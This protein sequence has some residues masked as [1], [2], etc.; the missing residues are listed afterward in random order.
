[1]NNHAPP[2]LPL[3]KPFLAAVI[4]GILTLACAAI[5]NVPLTQPEQTATLT[6][7]EAQ[8]PESPADT[9]LPT[10]QNTDN[11]PSAQPVFLPP[12][13]LVDLYEQASR[14][15]V[16]IRILS[17]QGGGLG[18]GFVIDKA[19]YIVTNF[20]VIEG[21]TELE[22]DFPD[23][24]KVRGEVLGTDPDSDLAIL[25]VDVP[26]ERLYPLVL[27]DSSQ[28]KVGQFVVAIGNPFGLSGTMT[29]GI[30]SA[31]GRVL[32]SLNAAPG[33]N[34]FSAGDIIQTDAAINPGNSGGPLLNLKGEVIGINR[35]IRTDNFTPTGSPTNSG[36]GFAISVN[37]LKRVAPSLIEKGSYEYPYLGVSS[38]SDI[39]LFDQEQL[40]LPQSTGA[41]IIEV[42]PGSPAEKGGLQA[43]DLITAIDGREV[44]VF[45]DLLSYLITEKS[46]GD[47]I[48]LTVL[49]DGQQIELTVTV[50]SRP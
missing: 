2:T 46:P 20:H 23:G 38:L 25:K 14:G 22:V 4:L 50:G 5:T 7:I 43:G 33:G 17:E 48:V 10:D 29:V 34:F 30:V 11:T 36:I 42:V 1:M 9:P 6:V 19:G 3:A 13:S 8:P 21:A 15:V 39:S 24:L 12:D 49:R 27:G 45:G 41:Y 37:I 32:E 31:K 35:A 40:G 28:V 26:P 47:D 18:S 44:F 16:S